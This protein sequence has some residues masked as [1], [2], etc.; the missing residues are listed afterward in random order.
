MARQQTR[1]EPV[2]PLPA[3]H[4]TV[5]DGVRWPGHEA[6]RIDEVVVGPSGVHVI[7]HDRHLSATPGPDAEVVA[8]ART[9]AAAVAGL[10]PQRYRGAVRPAVCLY[11]TTDVS[12][13][14]GDVRLA[15]AAP[16]WFAVRHQERVLSTSEVAATSGRLR[17]GLAPYPADPPAAATRRLRRAWLRFAAAALTTATAAT[18]VVTLGPGRLW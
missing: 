3:T 16:L 10:L 9:A 18:V 2:E 1:P 8:R 6:D 4:W 13:V 15:S 17:L 5:L 11:G 12:A 7:L 14:V